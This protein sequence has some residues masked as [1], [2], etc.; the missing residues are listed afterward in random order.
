MNLKEISCRI[1]VEGI[2]TEEEL[3]QIKALDPDY[4]QGY[5]YG[6]PSPAD[7]FLFE[8]C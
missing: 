7:E 2:E 3:L 6:R 1:C 4:I 8:F 5:Y